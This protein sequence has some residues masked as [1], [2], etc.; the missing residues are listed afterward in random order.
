[1]QEHIGPFAAW[2]ETANP[3]AKSAAVFM[4]LIS[5][6]Y[7]ESEACRKELEWW[8]Q[9]QTENG[10][11]EEDRLAIVHISGVDQSDP[12]P[13]WKNKLWAE[14][15]FTEIGGYFF[16]APTTA[17]KPPTSKSQETEAYGWPYRRK[18]KIED[19]RYLKAIGDLCKVLVTVFN[20]L[21][22]ESE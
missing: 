12:D 8:R 15:G 11:S 18:G 20:A 7:P 1:D 13:D 21:R 19:P 6:N 10:L 16:C 22:K 3:A 4:P 9:A 2:P 5:F 17:F 14:R